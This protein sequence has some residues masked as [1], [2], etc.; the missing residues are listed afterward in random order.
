MSKTYYVYIMASQRN[1]TVYT[2]VTNDIGRRAWEHREGLVPGFTKK[3]GVKMLVWYETF[4]HVDD[5]IHRETR[6]KKFTRRRKLELI[7]SVNP[8][9]HDLARGL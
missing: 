4:V 6:L 9:W 7:E 5:A 8:Q 2:G 3:Y 1:G